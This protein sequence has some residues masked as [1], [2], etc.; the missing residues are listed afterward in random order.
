M[1]LTRE[2]SIRESAFFAAL[3]P[4]A[5]ETGFLSGPCEP[6]VHDVMT[7][8]VRVG[9]MYCLPAISTEPYWTS[10]SERR[11]GL[12]SCSLYCVGSDLTS[13]FSTRRR[14]APVVGSTASSP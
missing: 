10:T 4:S 3:R 2:N 12:L 7:E 1:A 5:L 14:M 11:S 9:Q 6:R 8:T 13:A